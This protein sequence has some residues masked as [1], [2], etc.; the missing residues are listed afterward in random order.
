MKKIKS[1]RYKLLFVLLFVGLIPF[2]TFLLISLNE[3]QNAI[4]KNIEHELKA[5]NQQLKNVIEKEFSFYRNLVFLWSQHQIMDDILVDDIDKRIS[6]FIK[7][8]KGTFEPDSEIIVTNRAGKIIASTE[9]EFLFKKFPVELLDTYKF[10]LINFY[11]DFLCIF[12]PVYASFKKTHIGYII[13]LIKPQALK[14]FNREGKSYFNYIFN[15]DVLPVSLSELSYKG[16]SEEKDYFLYS[17]LL[18]KEI[19]REKWYVI[20]GVYKSVAFSP[21]NTIKDSLIFIGFLGTLGIILFS[22]L[23]SR[24]VINPIEQLTAFANSIA[25][26]KNYKQRIKIDSNDEI[27]ILA[28]SFNNLL[29]EINK[30][31]MQLRKESKERLILFIK[32]IDFF[33]ELTNTGEKEE[34]FKTL[35]KH[36]KDF[37]ECDVVLVKEN[38]EP[39]GQLKCFPLSYR[40]YSTNRE[41][42]EG[43]LCFSIKKELS[44]EEEKF[45]SSIS[46]LVSLWIERLNMIRQ[47][48]VLLEKAQSSSKAKSIF[49]TN[50]SHEL[51]TPLNSIIGFSQIIETS[52][53]LPEE[54]RDMAR[55]IRV[56]GEHLLSLINDILDFAK[57][58]ANKIKVKKEYFNLGELIEE[59]YLIVKPMSEQ[60]SLKL[61]FPKDLNLKIYTDRKLLKQ[62]LLNLLSNAVKFTDEGYVELNVKKEN[63]NLIFEVK[64]TGI[65]ISKENLNRIF[66]DFHQIENPLQKKYRG[67]GLGL[68]LVKRLVKLL[69]GRI[70][71]ESEGIGKG[72][73]FRLVLY[74]V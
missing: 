62:I 33:N 26:S 12:S 6:R 36:I 4:R 46:K 10:S 64:D 7:L 74:N 5:K 15:R 48:Q 25:Q 14:K 37:L 49:I 18:S 39:T 67:T 22:I 72:T 35:K 50:M 28:E 45:L 3:A 29:N 43:N 8:V 55:S 42:K 60:K 56:S 51:R 19:F 58:E 66:E 17:Q 63:R 69:N 59:I 54:Y 40:D 16:F 44:Y 23:I 27:A 41:V 1:L 57:A 9:K 68:A 11:S 61:I 32:L 34:V 47:L 53:E 21:I 31:I 52:E 13:Y 20:T 65:G 73:T 24:I 2:I 70:E 38:T 30:A 71:V